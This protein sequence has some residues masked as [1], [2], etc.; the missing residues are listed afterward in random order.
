MRSCELRETHLVNNRG[1]YCKLG[2]SGD[3]MV[4][5]EKCHNVL[6]ISF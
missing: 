6:W 1:E 2:C 3:R 5:G 4:W